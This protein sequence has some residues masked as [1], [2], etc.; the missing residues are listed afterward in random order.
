[1]KN[2]FDNVLIGAIVGLCAPLLTLYIFYLI[3]YNYLTFS[4][5]Y[6]KILIENNIVTPSI[7]LCV[8]SNLFI[9]FIFI[10]SNLNRSARGVLMTSFVYLGY[11]V[12]Q[13]YI[14]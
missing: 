1:V 12:Y 3:K 6:H 13:K 5:F 9:F 10:W 8:I 7:S 2:K 14:K 4:E 11:V